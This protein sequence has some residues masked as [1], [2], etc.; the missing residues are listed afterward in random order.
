M[1]YKI[2]GPASITD[3]AYDLWNF[4]LAQFAPHIQGKEHEE[5]KENQ[6]DSSKVKDM[7]Y[8]IKQIERQ[9]ESVLKHQKI[10]MDNDL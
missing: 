4:I 2:K 1:S 10:L 3:R 6:E 7:H 5:M 9:V 8:H